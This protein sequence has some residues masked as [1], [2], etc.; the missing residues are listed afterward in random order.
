MSSIEKASGIE[1]LVCIEIAER[2]QMGVK[3]YGTTV[4]DNPLPLRQWLEH[5]YQ[6][7]LDG[8]IY[9]RRAMHAIDLAAEQHAAEKQY[10]E[11]ARERVLHL[12]KQPLDADTINEITR[13]VRALP[14]LHDWP[15]APKG[16]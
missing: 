10:I 2:Q 8:A 9:L 15:D 3:K 14:Q 11:N 13:V 4:I 16:V 6:E 1:R 5:A 12:C 7:M